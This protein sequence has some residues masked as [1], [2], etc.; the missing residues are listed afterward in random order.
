MT[1]LE[2]NGVDLPD[3]AFIAERIDVTVLDCP[4]FTRAVDG[5][6]EADRE[7]AFR[8]CYRPSCRA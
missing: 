3:I 1:A 7:R 2:G 4:V 5:L 6:A 8:I